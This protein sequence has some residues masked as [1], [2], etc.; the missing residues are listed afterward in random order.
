[1]K[2]NKIHIDDKTQIIIGIVGSSLLVIIMAFVFYFQG[3][4]ENYNYLKE[5]TSKYIVYT[6]YEDSNSVYY[7]NVPYLNIKGENAKLI[8]ENIDYLVGPLLDK[9]SVIISYE[10]NINGIILSL[11][12]KTADYSFGYA[13][14]PV[15]VS[16]NY[17]LETNEIIS[18]KSLLDYFET[19]EEEAKNIIDSKL[20][21][22]YNQ[23]VEEEYYY[24]EECDYDCFLDYRGITD[25]LDSI[26]Y[27]VKDQKLYAYRP[28]TVSSVF[29][30]EEF[31][32]EENFEFLIATKESK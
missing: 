9:E 28:F 21:E 7:V 18:D 23:I 3:R 6:K 5:D 1:M 30:E 15:F 14:E 11:L 27:Y 12:I 26:S 22:Y 31:F 19:D 32:E 10:Y 17:N 13:V 2:F 8:N 25:I 4:S 16:Y 29:G 24:E 20:H